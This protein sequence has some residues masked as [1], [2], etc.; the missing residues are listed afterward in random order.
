MLMDISYSQSGH[1]LLE[2]INS[3]DNLC[4]VLDTMIVFQKDEDI[5]VEWFVLM[6]IDRSINFSNIL[7]SELCTYKQS[8][9]F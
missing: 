2:K 8:Q 7:Q 3:F 9:L 1:V 4:H 6:V 5:I